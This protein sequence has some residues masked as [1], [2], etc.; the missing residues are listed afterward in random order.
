MGEKRI[1]ASGQSI[2]K[3]CNAAGDD[4]VLAESQGDCWQT[5][6]KFCGDDIT[7]NPTAKPCWKSRIKNDYSVLCSA[8]L[9]SQKD[10]CWKTYD[11]M[12][13]AED[14]PSSKEKTC[15]VSRIK[16]DF[17]HKCDDLSDPDA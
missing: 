4:A 12:C 16:A 13:K 11:P 2:T 8:V 17:S 1:E 9:N 5:Y 15:W 10:D 3:Q 7:T 6:D 14:E